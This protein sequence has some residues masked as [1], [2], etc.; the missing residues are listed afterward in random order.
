MALTEFQRAVCRLIARRRVDS[1]ESYVAVGVALNAAI[2]A[3]R[4]S[5]DVDLFHDTTEAV[6]LSWQADRALLETGGFQVRPQRE[7]EGFVEAVVSRGTDSVVVQWAA[8][9]AF[10]F[11]LPQLGIR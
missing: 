7:R 1:G 9:S 10:R 8:D 5:R 11:R 6:S 2:K 3:A 4:I